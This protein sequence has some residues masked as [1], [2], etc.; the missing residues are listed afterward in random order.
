MRQYDCKVCVL[1][2]LD[3]EGG[4]SSLLGRGLGLGRPDGDSGAPA[5]SETCSLDSVLK[6]ESSKDESS[7]DIKTQ[8][9]AYKLNKI[10]ITKQYYKL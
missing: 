5:L 10:T 2:L 7:N 8:I 1:N 4:D 6:A 3:T 9:H